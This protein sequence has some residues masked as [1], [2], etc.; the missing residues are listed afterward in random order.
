M[1]D[2]GAMCGS[3]GGSDL[4][5]DL[6]RFFQRKGRARPEPLLERLTVQQFQN[7][8]GDGARRSAEVHRRYDVPVVK[9]AD[10]PGFALEPLHGFGLGG[11]TASKGLD[12][13]TPSSPDVLCFEYASHPTFGELPE[14]AILAIQDP[15]FAARARPQA[16]HVV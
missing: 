7:D 15:P 6:R 16:E 8:V 4:P 12:G 5:R 14:Q 3:Q 2:A 10:Q 1:D 13:D 11:V 9:T